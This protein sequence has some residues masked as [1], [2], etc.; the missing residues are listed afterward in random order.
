MAEVDMSVSFGAEL[1]DG[2]KPVSGGIAWLDDIQQFYRERSTI[3][4][5]YATKLNAL[6][7]RYF[8]K[9]AKKASA[10]SVGENPV[11]T[12]GSLESA[13][14]STWTTQLNTL[15]QRAAEHDKFATQLVT[16]LADP[17]KV[18]AARYEE[19]RK[20]HVDYAGKLE[21]ERDGSYGELR[22]MK[23]KY[24]T[25]CQEVENRRKKIDGA[26]DGGRSKAQIAYQQ[27][28][29]EMHN[30]KNTYIITINVTNKQKE[31]YYHEYVPELLDDLNE[32]RIS[33][34]NAV[35]SLGAQIETSML[36]HSTDLLNHLS[37]EIPRNKPVLDSMMFVR[38]NAA[39]WQ[40][41]PD[42]AFEA[43]P[44]WLDD[45]NIA[46]DDAAK[47]FLRNVLLKSK[48]QL[49]ELR[50]EESTKKREV[51]G[52]RR[53]RKSVREGKDKRDEVELV[54]AIF[55]LQEALHEVE[56]RKVTV[57]VE[58]STITSAVGDV[59]IGAR[60]HNFKS[61]TFK[62]PT[63]CDYCGERIWGINAK[64]FNCRACGFTCHSK[65]EMKV[66]ADC[67]GDQ[68][69]E[70]KKRLKVERQAAAHVATATVP[71]S[72]SASDMPR[73]S[74]SDTMNTLSSGF[75]ATGG[76][77]SMSGSASVA[78]EEEPKP[79]AKPVAGRRRIAAPPPAQYVS[80]ATN[81]SSEAAKPRE[82]ELRGR[83]RYPYQQN[84]EGEISVE[85]GK[86][87][88]ILEPDD[89]SG[90]MKV[91][92][93]LNEGLVPASYVEI[94]TSSAPTLSANR[95][96]STH[97]NSSISI[98]GSMHALGGKKKGPVVAP[99]RGAKKLKYVE[100]LYS[101]EAR[102]DAEHDMVEGE[103]FVLISKDSGDGW[104]EVEKGGVVKS[105]PANYIHEVA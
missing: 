88:T 97:S 66:P 52:A 64:G 40:E 46:A 91:R 41:P 5:E 48:G 80:D 13:S 69:K 102:S 62:I 25:V 83:M 45:D 53:V 43:S 77:R 67:P 85:D 96:G 37:S 89:G 55:S 90:W 54:R 98:S 7:K 65:C 28:L 39:N 73:M 11:V 9:K 44:V 42:M 6:A 21:K 36:G 84:G 33:T 15:E 20:L 61:E 104:A 34:L 87:V 59:S 32:T 1:K 29:A 94:I 60:N 68:N 86:E 27:Q 47:T 35:W 17:L 105:V 30:V 82:R 8:E 23:G 56:R 74:R 99:K 58:I 95:P 75:S 3:E 4:K 16:S 10:L 79:T 100:A 70:E 63:N 24:D 12:P 57:E 38:H 76:H 2:F 72:D 14:M 101:Y 71:T 49:S 31:K 103:R 92:F 50:T 93:Y 18:L 51:E 26:F 78:A 81:G 22:K 19:L